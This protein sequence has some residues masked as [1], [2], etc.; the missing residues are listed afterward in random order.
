MIYGLQYVC[1]KG[2]D[3]IVAVNLWQV[4]HQ[5]KT[6]KHIVKWVLRTDDYPVLLWTNGTLVFINHV[7]IADGVLF[8]L[9]NRLMIDDGNDWTALP[10]IADKIYIDMIVYTDSLSLY[11]E[12]TTT[13]LFTKPNSPTFPMDT[14]KREKTSW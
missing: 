5:L 7:L 12:N 1:T 14:P 3:R 6:I 9:D 8:V 2:P 4:I 13:R 11:T 10:Q